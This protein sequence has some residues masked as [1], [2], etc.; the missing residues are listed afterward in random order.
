MQKLSNKDE[1]NLFHFN[2]VFYVN[3]DNMKFMNKDKGR[4]DLEKDGS[5]IWGFM[6]VLTHFV[7]SSEAFLGCADA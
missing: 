1:L 5:A 3:C 4:V 2:R 6:C 7:T